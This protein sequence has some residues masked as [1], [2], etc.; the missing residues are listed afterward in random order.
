[1]IWPIGPPTIIISLVA[2]GDVLGGRPTVL[3]AL[4]LEGLAAASRSRLES[5]AA[6]IPLSDRSVCDIRALYQ[7]AGVFDK[8]E[9]L[10]KD[11][12]K[13]ARTVADSVEP[14]A[15]CRLLNYLIDIVLKTR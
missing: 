2:A 7:E 15:L 14:T 3:W 5:L 13:R 1:M 11:Y 9:R 4:A 8:A 6:S 10:V 12:E